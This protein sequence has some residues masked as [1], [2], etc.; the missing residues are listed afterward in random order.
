MPSMNPESGEPAPVPTV[1]SEAGTLYEEVD[2]ENKNLWIYLTSAYYENEELGISITFP[3]SWL[4]EVI[5]MEA[6][7]AVKVYF[8]KA[9]E[10]NPRLGSMAILFSYLS[11]DKTEK[12]TIEDLD[13]NPSVFAFAETETAKQFISKRYGAIETYFAD[14]WDENANLL[15]E[16]GR[17]IENSMHDMIEIID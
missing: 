6:N 11:V 1:M 3:E 8:R 9:L 12:H 10:E 15:D 2:E 14:I 13:D 5:L 17:A 16:M 7:G 4:D